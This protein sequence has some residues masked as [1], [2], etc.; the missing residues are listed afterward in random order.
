MYNLRDRKELQHSVNVK[1]GMKW[2]HRL[3]EYIISQAINIFMM[4]INIPY[5]MKFVLH[6]N[7]VYLTN[8]T[9]R[10]KSCHIKIKCFIKNNS[11]DSGVD[12][13]E[14]YYYNKRDV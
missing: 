5:N 3:V 12:K 6:L 9:Y 8:L 7:H 1:E 2:C 10:G 13:M 14:Y 4:L 11:K